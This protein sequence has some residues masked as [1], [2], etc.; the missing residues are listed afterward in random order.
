MEFEY[1]ED[2]S[3]DNLKKHGISL[4][5]AK[6][7][8]LGPSIEI[9]GHCDTEPRKILIGKIQDKFYSCVYT[10]R[11]NKIRLI[12]LRRS[13]EKE[14]RLYKEVFHEKENIG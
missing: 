6:F 12:S 9:E 11:A 7:L 3:K 1:H 10:F 4:A 5:D 2:K 14:E 8:W 13:R